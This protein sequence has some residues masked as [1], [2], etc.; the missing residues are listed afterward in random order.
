MKLLGAIIAGGQSSR[1]GSDKA[2]ALLDG[3]PL[4]DHVADGLRGQTSHLVVCGRTWPGLES[5]PDRPAPD[6][7]PL[8]GLCGALTY[9]HDHGFDAVLTAGCD[10]LPIPDSLAERLGEG[11]SIV[12]GQRLLGL[13]PVRLLPRLE[14][15]LATSD[16]RSLRGWISLCNA[17]EISVDTSFHNI[18]TT[19]D[20]DQLLRR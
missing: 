1:F 2:L 8:G 4:I 10:V 20:L 7:G 9:A 17:K 5:V 6:L 14:K 18:N 12:A 3:R 15:R 11:P 16:D 19:A 13:W